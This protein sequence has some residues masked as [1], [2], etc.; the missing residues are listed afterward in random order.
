MSATRKQV[1]AV[2]T[3]MSGYF[4]IRDPSNPALSLSFD[5]ID[6]AVDTY[7]EMRDAGDFDED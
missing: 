7:I 1:S 3:Y 6:D 5:D 4:D 2:V